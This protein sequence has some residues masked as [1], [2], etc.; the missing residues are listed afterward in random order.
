MKRFFALFLF[1]LT[2]A[3][4]SGQDLI[5]TKADFKINCK[6][7]REDSLSLF[8]RITNHPSDLEIKKTEVKEYY[9]N[10]LR[11]KEKKSPAYQSSP[12]TSGRK[13]EIVVFKLSTGLTI[14][15]GEFANKNINSETA[16][17][18]KSGFLFRGSMIVKLS[19]GFG[20]CGAY[21][22]QQNKISSELIN[23]QIQNVNGG[24]PFRTEATNWS[25]GGFF[26]GLYLEQNLTR[27]KKLALYVTT[28]I[29]GVKYRSPEVVSTIAIPGVA[30]S[31]KQ[32]SDEDR[33]LGYLFNAGLRVKINKDAGFHFGFSYF[34]GTATFNNVV[35][36]NTQGYSG[37]ASFSQ[38]FTTL[39]FEAGLAISIGK[40]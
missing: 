35:V 3:S 5:I 18:A 26:G 21:H 23:Q 40:D 25:A 15:L 9:Y 29:G 8:Y 24:V 36:S 4:A 6:I 12:V 19:E 13:K 31:A 1:M 20:V 2:F 22:L 34:G 32:A 39:N 28:L 27:E 37:K 16:G 11:Q 17:L 38:R 33:G 30:F 10:L 14:P 7:V